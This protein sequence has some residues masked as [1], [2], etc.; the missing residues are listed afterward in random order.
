[1]NL[2]RNKTLHP[3]LRDD[4]AQ[5]VENAIRL[6]IDSIMNVL[7]GVNSA[8]SYEHQRIVADKDKE[9]QWLERR[10][11]Q[12][13]DEL[14]ALRRQRGSHRPCEGEQSLGAD[15]RGSGEPQDGEQWGAERSTGQQECEMSLSLGLSAR[16]SSH[17]S[18]QSHESTLR[19]SP[20]GLGLD[21]SST[22]H[23]S[24]CSGVSDAARNLPTSPSSIVVKEEPCDTDTVFIKWGMTE[25]R[26]SEGPERR[27]HLGQE[28]EIP[29]VKTCVFARPSSHVS[30]QSHESALT[31][32]PCGQGL[33][34]SS[35]SHS[36]EGSGVS[37]TARNL[38]TSPSNNVVKEEPCDI[39]TVLLKWGMTEERITE[40]R[41][42]EE[43]ITEG[44]ERGNHLGQ[45]QERPAVK[46]KF[47]NKERNS[48]T[49]KLHADLGRQSITEKEHLRIKKKHVPM[50]E[51]PEE[52]Q[53]HRR[54]AWRAASRRYYARKIARQQ[55]NPFHHVI[56]SHYTQPLLSVDQRRTPRPLEMPTETP[57]QQR[58]AWRPASKRHYAQKMTKQQADPAQYRLQNME[59]RG[60]T[61]GRNGRGS[62]SNSGGIMCS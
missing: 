6:A 4:E 15:P 5:V 61:L 19:F 47:G 29:G 60:E 7:Y 10:L 21:Q 30:A 26:I 51:L 8:K 18:T 16:P 45:A 1:M 28:Q 36:S 53:K 37:D 27:N 39:G 50:S 38:S 34:Q 25:E 33:D 14:Q 59:E 32:S 43:R 40:E 2:V 55:A 20:I 24:E 54:A 62:H 23:S 46:K 22:V 9:I 57:T 41:I 49:R 58:E 52:V 56:N 48:L 42:T 11:G 13:E 3:H 44:P 12:V 31:S 35:T 17:V